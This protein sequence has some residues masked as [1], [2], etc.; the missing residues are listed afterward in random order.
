MV[1]RAEVV[2]LRVLKYALTRHS[3]HGAPTPGGYRVSYHTAP[4]SLTT[5]MEAMLTGILSLS[6]ASVAQCL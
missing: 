3:Y 6:V 5:S 1:V 2:H 4:V